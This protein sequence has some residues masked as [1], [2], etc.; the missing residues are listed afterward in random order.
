MTT[1]SCPYDGGLR[2]AAAH[3]PSGSVIATSLASC[4][5]GPPRAAR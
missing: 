2:C 5:G 3:G 1:I 4:G